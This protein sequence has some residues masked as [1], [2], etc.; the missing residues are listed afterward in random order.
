MTYFLVVRRLPTVYRAREK[1]GHECDDGRNIATTCRCHFLARR[2]R[3]IWVLNTVQKYCQVS[4]RWDVQRVGFKGIGSSI[5]LGRLAYPKAQEELH[6]RRVRQRSRVTVSRSMHPVAPQRI[7]L[8]NGT[9]RCFLPH[10]VGLL[11]KK[12]EI[13][14][15]R[16]ATLCYVY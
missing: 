6:Q 12:H 2:S 16:L 15:K 9:Q 3:Y 5:R 4:G 1:L 14:R 10:R 8:V 11:T 7:H 13:C